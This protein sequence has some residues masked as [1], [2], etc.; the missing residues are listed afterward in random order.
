MA[1]RKKY[2]EEF[3]RDAVDL[4]R[5]SKDRTLTDIARSLGIHLET[6]ATGF[7]KTRPGPVRGRQG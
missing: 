3:K 2:P 4:V 5:S 1:K 7:V 6:C